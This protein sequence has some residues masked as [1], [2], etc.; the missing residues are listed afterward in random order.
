MEVIAAA[1]MTAMFTPKIWFPLV[2]PHFFSN[3]TTWTALSIAKVD[4]DIKPEI[5]MQT[6]QYKV[7]ISL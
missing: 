7:F 4:L 3:V 2:L 6:K 1:Q 5:L